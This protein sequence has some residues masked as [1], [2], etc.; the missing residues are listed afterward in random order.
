MTVDASWRRA[1]GP[2][3]VAVALRPWLWPV[4]VV[5]VLRLARPRWWRRWPPVPSPDP[6][7]WRF[8]METAYGGDGGGRPAPP[9]V[10][11]YLRWCRRRH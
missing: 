5:T 1:V 2:V 6:D 7:Y 11:D 8:R 4:A 9:D 3:L 10:V